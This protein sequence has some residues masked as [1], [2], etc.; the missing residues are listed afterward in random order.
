MVRNCKVYQTPFP[1]LE[2]KICIRC[3]FFKINSFNYV[4]V[5]VLVCGYK[6]VQEV[7]RSPGAVV[8]LLRATL[9]WN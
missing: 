8:Q 9:I 4:Y 3:F 7:C 6:G 2:K 5:Y 1:T